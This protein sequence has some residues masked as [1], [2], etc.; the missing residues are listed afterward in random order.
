MTLRA[1]ET[2]LGYQFTNKAL[3]QQALTHSS[4][5]ERDIHT[6]YERLEFLGD[7]VLGL[8]LSH[9]L[10]EHYPEE[11]EGG[12]AK[13]LAYLA[14]M[15]VLAKVATNLQLHK[16]IGSRLSSEQ[17]A[18]EATHDALLADVCESIIAAIYLDGG[19]VPAQNFIQT[20][21]QGYLEDLP[22]PPLDPKS[23][24]QEW[25]Q[26]HEKRHPTYQLVEKMGPDHNPTYKVSVTIE[27]F[28]S[29]IGAGTSIR[30]AEKQAAE[31]MLQ[32]IRTHDPSAL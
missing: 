3:L 29:A 12:L 5:A 25:L 7:R 27:P 11:P 9:M 24:L 4:L 23:E 16:Y 15:P 19:L 21:W 14:S 22:A 2:A 32:R 17:R 20:Q 28:G 1:L 13:R 8:V 26:A 6:H 10:L 18:Q 31:L 30:Q